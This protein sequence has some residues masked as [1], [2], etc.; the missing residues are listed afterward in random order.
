[1]TSKPFFS[2]TANDIVSLDAKDIK[3][4]LSHFEKNKTNVQ[5]HNPHVHALLSQ[6]KATGGKVMGQGGKC[7]HLGTQNTVEVLSRCRGAEQLSRYQ[8]GVE[9]PSR[10]RGTKQ[11]PSRDGQVVIFF[12]QVKSSQVIEQRCRAS[13]QVKSPVP[14]CCVK[15][16]PSQ[17]SLF[18]Q[19]HQVKLTKSFST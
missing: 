17:V 11:M 2:K 5:S 4:V 14:I 7:W 15:S 10:C 9:V 12:T 16:K 13:G 19:S 3:Q 8:V 1:M 18:A 6:I